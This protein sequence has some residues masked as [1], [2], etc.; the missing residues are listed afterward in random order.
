M[1]LICSTRFTIPK[2]ETINFITGDIMGKGEIR[3]IDVKIDDQGNP[4]YDKQN[5]E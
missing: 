1:N 4:D 3:I 5:Y 2:R